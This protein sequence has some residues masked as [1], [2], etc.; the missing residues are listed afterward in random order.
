MAAGDIIAY[1]FGGWSTVAKVPTLG[2]TVGQVTAITSVEA[3]W[4]LSAEDTDWTLDA[5]PEWALSENN[6]Q[7]TAD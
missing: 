6:I 4:T 2:F 1:G 5:S 3:E 7:W